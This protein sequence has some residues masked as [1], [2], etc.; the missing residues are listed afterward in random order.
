VCCRCGKVGLFLRCADDL[1]S[2]VMGPV[3]ANYPSCSISNIEEERLPMHFQTWSAE[4]RLVP[5]LF[6]ILRH[7]QFED[8][9]NGNFSD[10]INGILRAVR[11]TI[12][13]GVGWKLRQPR[14]PTGA[15]TAR[16]RQCSGSTV[17]V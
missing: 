17:R 11:P 12:T 2:L 8:L 3:I 15:A 14:L 1:E 6:P 5:E 9:L 10:P 16:Q 13:C 4:I 7:A